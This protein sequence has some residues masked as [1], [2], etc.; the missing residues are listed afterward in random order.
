MACFGVAC[1][2]HHICHVLCEDGED[3]CGVSV[4]DTC[5]VTDH[6]G[7]AADCV[8][9]EDSP[10]HY[11]GSGAKVAPE[12]SFIQDFLG[13]F[14]VIPDVLQFLDGGGD[15]ICDLILPLLD[16]LRVGWKAGEDVTCFLGLSMGEG[17]LVGQ[18]GQ[19]L[20]CGCIVY[21][22]C[23]SSDVLHCLG[24]VVEFLELLG[25]FPV[26]EMSLDGWFGWARVEEDLV[27]C[28]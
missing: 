27:G 4:D 17:D 14:P 28:S 20:F 2:C 23:L 10:V 16:H 26:E 7:A 1:G 15:L 3:A 18:V 25:G 9:V 21:V 19:L 5:F 6:G 22:V 11:F 8:V 13:S 12:G 24:G